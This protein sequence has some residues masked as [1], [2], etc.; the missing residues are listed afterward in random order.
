M[1]P[2]NAT[3]EVEVPVNSTTN[4]STAPTEHISTAEA[5]TVDSTLKNESLEAKEAANSSQAA[6]QRP[7]Y[8][9]FVCIP[10]GRRNTYSTIL[11][12]CL[13]T[14]AAIV[15]ASCYHMIGGLISIVVSFCVSSII[16]TKILYWFPEPWTRS[17]FIATRVFE[18]SIVISVGSRLSQFHTDYLGALGAVFSNFAA[19]LFSIAF[20]ASD[21]T[22]V[23]STSLLLP[24]WIMLL[25]I[26]I[27][28]LLRRTLG[29]REAA[30]QKVALFVAAIVPFCVATLL[31]WWFHISWM[32]EIAM[33]KI[34]YRNTLVIYLVGLIFGSLVLVLRHILPLVQNAR[35]SW[36][37]VLIILGLLTHIALFNHIF[38]NFVLPASLFSI[39][40]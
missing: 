34:S 6:T 29:P 20:M 40:V 17:L 28:P 11:G 16:M 37:L 30:Q 14:I 1:F 4:I 9:N 13:I 31:N 8:E 35:F 19:L 10:G 15:S 18:Y 24:L 38:A 22:L 7:F 2:Y 36:N 26:P 27:I 5:T 12:I 25:S 39:T 21:E 3:A 23:Q 32:G 33:P